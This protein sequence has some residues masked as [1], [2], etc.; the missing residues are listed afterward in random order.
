MSPFLSSRRVA[1]RP[2]TPRLLSK[3]RVSIPALASRLAM[4]RPVRPAPMI[5]TRGVLAGFMRAVAVSSWEDKLD[6][7][8]VSAA[9][10]ASCPTKSLI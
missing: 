7:V 9:I 8:A 5:A 4:L 1:T 6:M 3:S 2:P 10:S